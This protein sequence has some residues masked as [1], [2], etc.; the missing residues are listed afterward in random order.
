MPRSGL[1]AVHSFHPGP[2]DIKRDVVPQLPLS[3]FYH[4][5]SPADI[6]KEGSTWAPL[7]WLLSDRQFIVFRPTTAVSSVNGSKW[8][9]SCE[10]I[11]SKARGPECSPGC[12]SVN[13]EDGDVSTQLHHL[14]LP[15][16]IV[17]CSDQPLKARHQSRGEWL[18]TVVIY[19]DWTG[20]S[21]IQE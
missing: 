2:A 21:G 9:H 20:L 11:W 19:A 18:W 14:V 16:C 10:C 1:E 6:Q 17:R 3:K 12:I 15:I 4:L 5:L 8:L 13:G 7:S